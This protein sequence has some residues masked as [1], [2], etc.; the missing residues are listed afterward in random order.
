[1][2]ALRIFVSLIFL[3]CVIDINADT[4]LL[5]PKRHEVESSSKKFVATV[6]PKLGV[7]VRAVGSSDVLWKGPA[8]WARN[9]FLADDGEHFVTGY[10]GLNLIPANYSTDLVLITFWKKDQKIREVTVGELFPDP[11]VL[12]R[13]VSHYHWGGIRGI[14]GNTLIVSR[15]DGTQVTFDITTGRIKK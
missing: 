2:N 13:T 6:D 4:P 11:S 9:A 1:M 10:D 7:T 3:G 15:C 5:P 8:M 12:V 14:K